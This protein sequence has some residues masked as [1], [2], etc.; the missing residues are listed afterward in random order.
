[1]PN[2]FIY[3]SGFRSRAGGNSGNGGGRGGSK[4]DPFFSSVV[5]LMGFENGADGGTTFIDLSPVGRTVS[6]NG[7][8]QIDTAQSKFGTRSLLL[9]GSADYLSAGDSVSWFL[10]TG[11]FT[12]EAWV[13]FNVVHDF[14][15]FTQWTGGWVFWL[16]AGNLYFRTGSV[17]DSA[18]YAWSPSTG[19]W[20]HIACD[21]D[22]SDNMRIYVDGVMQAKSTGFNHNL[23]DAA[24]G[25]GIGSLR[26]AGFANWD[27]NGWM[28]ELRITKGVAR[29]ASDSGYTV[30][31]AAFPRN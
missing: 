22:G 9:D 1:M 23:T 3:R 11:Q 29:Y 18:K 27:H 8:A 30:P 24:T 20:Y 17:I 15:V 19:V 6:A 31:S 2:P 14:V 10:G 21:R 28:D 7:N 25:L 4:K 12:M 26:T 16:D 5:L 13:R